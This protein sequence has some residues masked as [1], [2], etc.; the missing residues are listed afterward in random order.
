MTPIFPTGRISRSSFV[1]LNWLDQSTLFSPLRGTS[2]STHFSD[3][4]KSRWTRRHR[5]W[6]PY[7]WTGRPAPLTKIWRWWD[8]ASRLKVLVRVY[9]LSA[10]D[11]DACLKGPVQRGVG[12]AFPSADQ[13]VPG[14]TASL[15]LAAG[16]EG[17]HS[18]CRNGGKG[19]E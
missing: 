9:V 19:T 7:V 15:R 14:L 2:W 4:T 6:L 3:T 13:R 5:P 10:A 17:R 18:G 16:A 12:A 1:F 11:F 8:R